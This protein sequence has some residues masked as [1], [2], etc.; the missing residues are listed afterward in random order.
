MNANIM[1]AALDAYNCGQITLEA[2]NNILAKFDSEKIAVAK[3]IALRYAYER[4]TS[5]MYIA[6]F[7]VTYLVALVSA[8]AMS[9][10]L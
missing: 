1:T 10:K 9:I 4:Y 3:G 2:Y 6:V 5:K 7:A 8:Y